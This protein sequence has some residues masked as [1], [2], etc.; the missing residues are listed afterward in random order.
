MPSGPNP[1][2]VSVAACR[3][4]LRI[5]IGQLGEAEIEDLDPAISGEE[6]VLRLD[7]A[8]DDAVF[9]RRRQ[10]ARNLDRVIDSP[11]EPAAAGR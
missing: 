1:S 11:R 3:V 7:V 2:T 8:V 5:G 6:Q 10:A 9:V 4:R